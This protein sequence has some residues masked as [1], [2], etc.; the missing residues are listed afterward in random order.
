MTFGPELM[1]AYPE[2]KV[3]LTNRD[4]DSWHRS[5]SQT[6]LKARWYWLHNILQHFDWVTGLVQPLRKKY[7]QCLFA[8]DFEANGKVAMRAHYSEICY[9]A[10]K[11]GREVLEFQLGDEWETLCKF[12]E[13]RVPGHPYPRENEGGNWIL[14]MRER[15]RLRANA[16]AYRFARFALPMAIIS[17]GVWGMMRTFPP[18]SGRSGRDSLLGG[19][20]GLIVPKSLSARY[21]YR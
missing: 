8:D 17:V 20:A 7:W 4:V 21:R 18:S 12:L 5:C 15:A 10:R 6:L 13:V 3:I 9:I 14:K 19:F 16:A 1:A 11:S 2:A